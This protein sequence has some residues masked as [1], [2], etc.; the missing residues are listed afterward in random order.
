M[1]D[2]KEIAMV[3]YDIINLLYLLYF[4]KL[5]KFSSCSTS[6]YIRI[7]QLEFLFPIFPS[8]GP[9]ARMTYSS[10]SSHFYAW[11]RETQSSCYTT[12]ILFCQ[13]AE[14]YFVRP[15]DGF[16]FLLLIFLYTNKTAPPYLIYNSSLRFS[17]PCQVLMKMHRRIELL[18]ETI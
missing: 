4:E 11:Q 15:L 3:N 17:A 10:S 2:K 1:T 9:C 12:S 14:S 16:R 13:T 8:G 6:H 5:K 18:C 7:S